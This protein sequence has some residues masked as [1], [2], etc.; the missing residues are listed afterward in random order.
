MNRILELLKDVAD[1]LAGLLTLMFV[2][3]G[4]V[5]LAEATDWQHRFWAVLVLSLDAVAV[6]A[7]LGG[8][9]TP[10]ISRL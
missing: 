9:E 10:A 2:V 5:M 4:L 7:F 1:R 6:W 3:V 8:K